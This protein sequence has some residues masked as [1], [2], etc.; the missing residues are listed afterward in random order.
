M[1]EFT[2]MLKTEA[3]IVL[4][5]IQFYN[6]RFSEK[7]EE[8][9]RTD[10]DLSWKRFGMCLNNR[11]MENINDDDYLSFEEDDFD[12]DF[13]EYESEGEDYVLSEDT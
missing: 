2:R 8:W 4:K 7:F 13:E 12:A 6:L 1:D 5:A 3:N 9:L 10:L 11:K